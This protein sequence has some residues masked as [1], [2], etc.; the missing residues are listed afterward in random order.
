MTGR[1]MNLAEYLAELVHAQLENRKP[2]PV[3]QGITAE[4]LSDIAGRNHMDY[5]ILGALLKT[6]NLTEER[7]GEFR[8]RVMSGIMKTAVQVT[9]LRELTGRFEAEKI[10]SQPMKGAC[11]KFVYPMPEMREM[12]DIDILIGPGCMEKAAGILEK[13][14]YVLLR[15]VKHHDIYVKRPYM[16]VEAHRAMYDKTVDEKQYRYFSDLSKAQLKEGHSYTYEFRPEDFYVYML[17]HMAKHFY[18]MGCGIRNLADI[19]VFRKKYDAAMDR[20][21]LMAEL[22]RC[23]LTAFAGHMEKMAAVWLG[24]EPWSDFYR[25]LFSYMTDSGIYGRDENGIWSKFA[26]EKM[27]GKDAAIRQLRRWY[28]FPPLHYMS[29]YYPWLEKRPFL[30]PAAWAVRAFGGLF[31]KKGIHKREMLEEIDAGKIREYQNI[32]REMQLKF[33]C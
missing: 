28:Y 12:S 31:K 10:V 8:R 15:S 20:A 23:G 14:G 19:Y 9:E 26:E 21:Y 1:E 4:Q 5:L 32:Y 18:K 22:D 29:E 11:L 27:Q 3:P 16:V 13:M 30:L 7:K 24:G 17:A 2:L 6:E 33:K 25:Q